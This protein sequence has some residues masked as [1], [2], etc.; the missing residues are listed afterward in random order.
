MRRTAVLTVAILCAVSTAPPAPAQDWA[1]AM[2]RELSHDFGTVAAYSKTEHRFLVTNKYKEDMHLL[3]V[4]SSCGCTS[5]SITKQTLKTGETAEVVAVFNTHSFRGQ[6]SA[7]LTVTLGDPYAAQVQL[8]VS[9]FIR[10]DVVLN[11]ASVNFG[12]VRQGSPAERT[13]DVSYAGRNDWKIADVRSASE[14]LQAELKE[15]RRGG[16]LVDYRLT[17]RLKEGAPQGYLSDQLSLVTNDSQGNRIPLDV[18]GKVESDLTVNPSPLVFGTV[19]AGEQVSKKIVVRGAA[20]FRLTSVNCPEG[21]SVELGKEAKTFHVV[22]VK[23][24]PTRP[25][26]LTGKIRFETD[27]GPSVAVEVPAHA[28]VTSEVKSGDGKGN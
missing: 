21:F 28:Q 7:V 4:R 22:E 23:L 2:F 8:R 20:P 26:T 10:G 14:Y 27:L 15:T 3:D 9:G 18:E 1:K 5:P 6:R 24:Q 16:G 19:K 13:I 17:V 25:G 11:P 12:R